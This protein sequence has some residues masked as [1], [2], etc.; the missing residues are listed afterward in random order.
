MTRNSE[1][2]GENKLQHTL[3]GNYSSKIAPLKLQQTKKITATSAKFTTN[4]T[5][6]IF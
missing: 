6:Q 4:T 2:K 3:Y 5:F 1:A